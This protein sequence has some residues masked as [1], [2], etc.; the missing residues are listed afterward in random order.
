[1]SNLPHVEAIDRVVREAGGYW[2]EHPNC[3]FKDWQNDV[4]K[5]ETRAGYHLYVASYLGYTEI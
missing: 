5:K 4:A 2:L 1:M 3:S